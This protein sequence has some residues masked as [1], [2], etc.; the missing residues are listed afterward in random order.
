MNS[1]DRFARARGL[2]WLKRLAG[3]HEIQC[4]QRE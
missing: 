2:E 4:S 3:F 1:D